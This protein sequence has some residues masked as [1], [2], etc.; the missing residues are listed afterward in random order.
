[1]RHYILW[2]LLN[3]RVGL[4]VVGV[5]QGMTGIGPTCWHSQ[6]SRIICSRS[7]FFIFFFIISE[8]PLE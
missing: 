3:S 1:M 5:F 6:I 8:I 2:S 4:K 7:S